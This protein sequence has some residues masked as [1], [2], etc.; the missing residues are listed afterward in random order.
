MVSR[1]R[2]QGLYDRVSL[3]GLHGGGEG[4]GHLIGSRLGVHGLIFE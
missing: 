1:V 2:F 4:R 3:Q